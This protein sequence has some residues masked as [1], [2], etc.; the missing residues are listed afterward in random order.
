MMDT[1]KNRE[2]LE[3][4][5]QIRLGAIMS[6]VAI[7]FSIAAGLV[8]TP[9]MVRKIGQADYGLYILALSV[10][11]YFV[12]D[13]GLSGSISR[14]VSKYR[15]EKDDQKVNQFLGIVYKLYIIIDLV[16]LV[17]LCVVFFFLENIFV[18]LTP[19]EIDKLRVIFC[20]AGLF[21]VMSL[22]F[23]TLNGILIAYERFAVLK[24]FEL[25]NRVITIVLMIIVLLLG[26]KLYALVIVNVVVGIGIIVFKVVYIKKNTTI[27]VDF[28]YK[29]K[30]T[31]RHILKFSAWI[32]VISVAQRFILN[33]T[34]TVLG[35]FSGTI[36]ISIFAI[37]MAI[38]GYTWTFANALNGL[39]LPKVTRMVTE[40][41]DREEITNLMIKVGRIQLIIVGLL[42]VGF[43][44]MGRQFM[45]LWMGTDF[46]NSYF[47]AVLLILPGVITY[48]QEIAYNLLMAIDEI[49]YRAV[50]HILAATISII[51]SVVLS[52]HYGAI[53]SAIGIFI[54]LMA[55][56]VIGM[57][58][59]YHKVL[60]INIVRFFKECHCKMLVP[61]VL[62][63][64]LG[65]L[66][67]NYIPSSN[68]VA[69]MAKA[70][71]LAIVYTVLMWILAMNKYE[72]DLF[73]GLIK[74]A[75]KVV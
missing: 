15:A 73:R 5:K 74:S 71:I 58:F 50:M 75:L 9:W 45:V 57:N 28:G 41:D 55:G 37:G 63:T 62:S 49:K 52:R 46:V 54:G 21:S 20:I 35:I 11:A 6:Y 34:P 60:K 36:Q 24:T 42:L 53:G 29:D 30:S 31:L 13:F 40:N 19:A 3:S 61:L 1:D 8:Y 68:L 17:A 56:S 65:F 69:F 70:G 33:I 16:I 64:A 39:F 66:I 44:S 72:K 26:Y 59:V 23:V 48:T 22:P 32:M 14:F 7:F 10:I 67:Q 2:T 47:V 4:A 27:N 38:E 51:L 18:Q 43:T 12:M 25:L